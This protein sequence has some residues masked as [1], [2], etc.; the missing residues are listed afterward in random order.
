MLMLKMKEI[1]IFGT[2]KSRKTLA[3]HEFGENC[4]RRKFLDIIYR[5]GNVLVEDG[6]S[7]DKRV[8][9]F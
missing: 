8:K 3:G 2:K 4:L 7:V 6:C 9:I 5:Q 1:I